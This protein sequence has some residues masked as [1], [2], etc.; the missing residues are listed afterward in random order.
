MLTDEEVL[1]ELCAEFQSH[2]ERSGLRFQKCKFLYFPANKFFVKL[3]L[4]SLM[5][6]S[7]RAVK[8]LIYRFL[9]ERKIFFPNYVEL[10][11]PVV[12]AIYI[13]NDGRRSCILIADDAETVFKITAPQSAHKYRAEIQALTLAGRF[14]LGPSFPVLK[15]SAG[16][17]GYVLL[18]QKKRPMIDNFGLLN[19]STYNWQVRLEKTILPILHGFYCAHGFKF[20][21]YSRSDLEIKLRQLAT[22]SI[23]FDED[24]LMYLLNHLPKNEVVVSG[25]HGGL[26][27]GHVIDGSLGTTLIDFDGYRELPVLWDLI[28][29]PL[30]RPMDKDCWEW[31]AGTKNQKIPGQLKIYFKIYR[32]YLF[33]NFKISINNEDFRSQVVQLIFLV[34]CEVH[35][36]DQVRSRWLKLL[37][38]I[39][40]Q[41]ARDEDSE[42]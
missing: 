30:S 28:W 8:P 25:V 6:H 4:K 35:Q 22:S 9:N 33:F 21:R 32:Q 10:I 23:Y 41:K 2:L 29:Y 19:P 11:C 40:T 24:R 34:V 15:L 13:R 18:A 14:K 16:S 31:I 36:L 17:R 27:P 26:E 1:R 7:M 42:K 38:L 3:E 5:A 37:G 39:R 12:D 20:I